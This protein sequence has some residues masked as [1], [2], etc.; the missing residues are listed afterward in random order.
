MIKKIYYG[1]ANYGQEE[2]NA[3]I[4]VLKK[5]S[6]TLMDGPKVREFETKVPKLFGKKF[7][8]MV[9]SGSSANLLALKSLKL[10]SGGE[11]ITPLLTFSTTIAP[12]YQCNLTPKFVDVIKNTFIAD[13][14]QVLKSINKKTVA[15][16]LP[17]LLGNIPDW[18]SIYLYC[19]KKNIKLI[20]DSADTIG[21]KID[22]AY[23]KYT[24][25]ST[26]SF[27]ASHLITGAGFGGIVCFNNKDQYKHALLLRGWGRSSALFGESESLK[28]RFSAKISNIDYDSKY[29]FSEMGYNFLPSE[30]SASF[31]L[32]Q[33]KKINIFKKKRN[34]N[35][36]F[37]KKTIDDELSD[38]FDTAKIKKDK[39]TVWLAFPIVINN[40]KIKRK[41]LQIFLEK[42]NIQTRTIFTGNILKQPCMKNKK[43]EI[44]N[45]KWTT[46]SDR[47]MSNGILLGCHH[48]LKKNQ[49]KQIIFYL[50]K[51]VN[52]Y[53]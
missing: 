20:E 12:I 43:Y 16:M 19:Q 8:L 11:V 9:N 1:K 48:G 51:F 32:E 39:D 49:L 42:K 18:K 10:K 15:I 31:A 33:L 5:S 50:K 53:R 35:F 45:S 17:N 3:V 26:S 29:I 6:L 2:I 46:E 24:D 23:Q 28:K 52:K 37:L 22:G 44:M 13:T 34:E 38:F 41:N 14:E 30:I 7:G 4:K 36:N 27:Y 40:S 21:F 47:V 25:I